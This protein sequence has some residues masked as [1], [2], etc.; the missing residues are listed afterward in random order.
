MT[1][2]PSAKDFSSSAPHCLET[3]I[4]ES[5]FKVGDFKIKVGSIKARQSQIVKYF[6]LKDQRSIFLTVN[7]LVFNAFIFLNLFFFFLNQ[8]NL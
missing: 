3:A 7:I 1:S 6:P 2:I 4:Y 5:I 8:I